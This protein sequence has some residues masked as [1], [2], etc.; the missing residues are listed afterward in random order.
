MPDF[1]L[2]FLFF[3][4][5]PGAIFFAPPCLRPY[6]EC[7]L[8]PVPVSTKFLVFPPQVLLIGSCFFRGSGSPPWLPALSLASFSPN[9]FPAAGYFLSKNM[10]AICFPH[11]SCSFSRCHAPI[12]SLSRLFNSGPR[13]F[14]YCVSSLPLKRPVHHFL[15]SPSVLF[16]PYLSGTL[17]L[18]VELYPLPNMEDL[19]R[20]F[21]IPRTVP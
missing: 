5:I 15:F 10:K 6:N 20:F 8:P 9:L 21:L 18:L 12:L 16:R 4:L 2:C 19:S 3:F 1:L 11:C 17:F 7:V 14:L 13:T